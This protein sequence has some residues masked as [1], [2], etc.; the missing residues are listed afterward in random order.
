MPKR[1]P[2]I[3][4]R[5]IPTIIGENP[6]ETPWEL[7]EK[8]V[9]KKHPFFGNK[10]TEHGVKYE[11]AALMLYNKETG[12]YLKEGI[13]NMKH[14]EYKWVTGR[15]DAVTQNNCLVEIKCPY[16]KESRIIESEDDVPRHYWGQCQV[17]MEMMDIE[18][19]HYVECFISPGSAKDGSEGEIS[20]IAICRNRD[21]WDSVLP[22]VIEFNDE[23]REYITKGD[24]ET[25]PV[26]VSNNEWDTK[27]KF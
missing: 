12:N 2:N 14:S 3:T 26:R 17:Y 1:I 25:H 19:C 8:K 24:L 6:Y 5:D 9:E 11:D 16:K 13:K 15:P 23:M 4:A 20:Y 22:K 21:W 18:V 27:Y 7:M 10:F